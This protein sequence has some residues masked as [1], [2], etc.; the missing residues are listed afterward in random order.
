[1]KSILKKMLPSVLLCL[2]CSCGSG[3]GSGGGNKGADSDDS[4][5]KAQ[6]YADIFD[7]SGA[8]LPLAKVPSQFGANKSIDICKEHEVLALDTC[9]QSMTIDADHG[10]VLLTNSNG[11]T[12]TL[13]ESGHS[14][15]H[16]LESNYSMRISKS[17]LEQEC[18]PDSSQYGQCYETFANPGSD[19]QF[20]KIPYRT[21][22]G[23]SNP[24]V[25]FRSISGEWSASN[26]PEVTP[27]VS[28][29]EI[30]YQS[31]TKN[32][33]SFGLKTTFAYGLTET[34]DMFH[35]FKIAHYWDLN[36]KIIVNGKSYPFPLT[37][38]DL[39]K[40]LTLE[41]MGSQTGYMDSKRVKVGDYY[42]ILYPENNSKYSYLDYMDTK[43]SNKIKGVVITPSWDNNIY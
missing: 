22:A 10:K 38:S 35:P 41:D 9:W 20:F 8:H 33:I 14:I 29:N 40:D 18:Y 32:I 3:G 12:V 24:R 4:H 42:L 1:M 17:F 43:L 28:S 37:F 11:D 31:G 27:W 23:I 19:S 5:D 7:S 34:N 26:L 15:R 16:E 30:T 36:G 21:D 25:S 2:V 39:Q 13:F 6:V